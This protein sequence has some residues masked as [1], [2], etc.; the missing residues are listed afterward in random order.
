MPTRKKMVESQLRSEFLALV[1][2]M[3]AAGRAGL[4]LSNDALLQ[5]IVEA[6]ARIFQAAA[7]SI[8]LV[9]DA[10]GE[11]IFVAST[12][13]ANRRLIGMRFPLD[14][15]IAGYVAM[16]G[17]PIAISDVEH[18]PRFHRDFAQ[19]TGYVPRSIL[20]MPLTSGERVLGVMEVL[21]KLDAP[22]FGM[23]DM[24][25]LALF[26]NQAALAIEMSQGLER[27][28][29]SLKMGMKRL[30]QGAGV[31]PGGPLA[32]LLSEEPD[33]AGRND[34]L[35]LACLLNEF[36]RLGEEERKAGLKI[37]EAFAGYA[38][39]KRRSGQGTFRR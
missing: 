19:S 29:E 30:A 5:S 10:T 6:A 16:S 17:Q 1:Q 35:E 38:R 12:G 9:D 23:Q 32:A 26:A 31:D 18:D 27:L 13:A 8:L 37:L 11:L 14:Q 20:A 28:G 15:G 7:A 4:P 39:E 2:A 33:L 36:S 3:E 22:A 34:L 21:D 25:L 24:D